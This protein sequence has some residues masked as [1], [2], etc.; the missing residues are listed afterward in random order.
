MPFLPPNQNIDPS[1]AAMLA[2]PLGMAAKVIDLPMRSAM[3]VLGRQTYRRLSDL[4]A[5]GGKFGKS[6]EMLQRMPMTQVW[7]QLMN[8]A[9][10]AARSPD[11]RGAAFVAANRL[12]DMFAN[13]PRDSMAKLE[14]AVIN[15][16]KTRRL[17]PK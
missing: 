13:W 1:D 17:F 5:P 10:E 14:E 4:L 16:A 11:A 9:P 3:R 2:G 6:S 12:S 8:H 15:A 7:E